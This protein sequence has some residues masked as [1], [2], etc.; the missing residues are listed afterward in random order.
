M[1][2]QIYRSLYEFMYAYEQI[3]RERVRRFGHI[4]DRKIQ[5]DYLLRDA[6]KDDEVVGLHR[7]DDSLDLVISNILGEERLTKRFTIL[8]W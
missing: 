6:L 4:T 8:D 2:H 1:E 7:N 5:F 3:E